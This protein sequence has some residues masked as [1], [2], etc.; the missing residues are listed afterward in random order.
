MRARLVN[1]FF[2]TKR[3]TENDVYVACGRRRND[4]LVGNILL[5]KLKLNAVVVF[6]ESVTAINGRGLGGG[7]GRENGENVHGER[8][9][10][11]VAVTERRLGE[12][13]WRRLS[14]RRASPP[15]V[16]KTF[17]WE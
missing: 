2:L 1:I 9:S 3:Q 11:Q 5:E 6:L 14:S 8:A 16:G 15:S 7:M 12:W 4:C 17:F 10:R 13:N